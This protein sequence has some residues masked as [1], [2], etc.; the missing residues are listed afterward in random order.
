MASDRIENTEVLP[1]DSMQPALQVSHKTSG[2]VPASPMRSVNAS[3]TRSS[4]ASV[5]TVSTATY[6]RQ[7]QEAEDAFNRRIEK[8]CQDLWPLRTSIKHRFLASQVATSLRT[9]KI[10]HLFVPASQIPQIQHL[11]GGG[12]NHIT[13]ITLPSSYHEGHRNLIL[14]VPREDKSRPD[15][16]VATLNY[17]RQRTSIPVAIVEATDFTCNNAVGKPYVLQHRIP[18]RDLE[19]VW[20]DLSH[21]QRCVVAR[22]VGRLIQNLLSVAS[23]FAGTITAT[24]AD[25]CTSA[26]LPNIVPFLLEDALGDLVEEL[27]PQNAMGAETA[28]S[29]E[30]TLEFFEYY[31][32][33]WK[34]SA[35]LQSHGEIGYDI[36]LYDEMLKV[37]R[38]MDDLGL[39][40]PDT[41]CLC[42]LDLYP[43]NIMVEFHS[44]D[45]IRVTGIL[46][47]DE[48]V[49][50]PKFVNCQP[51]GWL[52]GYDKDTHTE[53]SLLPWPYELEGANN[54][55]LTL[56]QQE[57]KVIFDSHAGPEYP[58]LAYDESSRLIRGL[59]RVATLGLTA[60]WHNT[61]AERIVK[62]WNVLRPT[63][64]YKL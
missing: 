55:P 44:E 62:E 38:E 1:T 13:S 6:E 39:F 48:A 64:A 34:N 30:T 20:D 28:R 27:E 59:Y 26:E 47:W 32:S 19:S 33:R 63:L 54:T 14:R 5:L 15:Q 24:A 21:S 31:L 61:A 10:F 16:Q 9:S 4:D 29:R 22:E 52:W 7:E 8:L 60:N 12:F 53:S 57:L 3:T 17:V 37:V 46:D 2:E 35:L 11:K 58:R 45:S 23:P 56:E 36:E 18:G 41:N 43:R 40:K 42:H 50:A 25:S 51:P 49:V